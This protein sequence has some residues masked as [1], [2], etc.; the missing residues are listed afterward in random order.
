MKGRE[1]ERQQREKEL[2]KKARAQADQRENVK[3]DSL[4]STK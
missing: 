1:K 2:E 3:P 4:I